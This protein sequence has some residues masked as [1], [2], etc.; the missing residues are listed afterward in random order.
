MAAGDYITGFF[1]WSQAGYLLSGAWLVYVAVLAVRRLWLSPIAHIPG[2][3]LAAL[4]QYLQR[5]C[6]HRPPPPQ[7]ETQRPQP[8]LLHA[9]GAEPAAGH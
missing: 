2:P 1:S 6:H 4:T 5:P 8:L 3:R 9:D 7:V